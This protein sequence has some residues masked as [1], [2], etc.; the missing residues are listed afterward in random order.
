MLSPYGRVWSEDRYYLVGWSDRHKALRHFRIDLMR[1]PVIL[2]EQAAPVPNDF[3]VSAYGTSIIRMFEG[4]PQQ[5]T[6]RVG[7]KLVGKLVDRFGRENIR[8]IGQAE[9]AITVIVPVSVGATFYGWLLQYAGEMQI[10]GPE[11]V[12]QG[13]RDVLRRALEE[14]AAN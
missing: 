3:D 11:H 5:V 13:Y 14:P 8:V 6:L 10:L 12:R 2:D 4:E 9:D 1:L 7:L